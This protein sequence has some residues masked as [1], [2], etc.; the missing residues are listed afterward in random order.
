VTALLRVGLLLLLPALAGC[1]YYHKWSRPGASEQEF[2]RD[3]MQCHHTVAPG[4][5]TGVGWGSGCDTLA[6]NQREAV[7]RCLRAQGWH[8][9]GIVSI[10]GGSDEEYAP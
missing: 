8:P 5:C 2:Y 6:R 3:S 9:V 4:W 1:L 7:E 10:T